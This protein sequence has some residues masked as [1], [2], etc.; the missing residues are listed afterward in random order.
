MGGDSGGSAALGKLSATENLLSGLLSGLCCKATNYPLLSW[1]NASQQN[2][3]LQFNISVYRGL[4]MAMMNL[5]WSFI[6][7]QYCTSTLIYFSR[8]AFIAIS[9]SLLSVLSHAYCQHAGGTTAV[10]FWATGFFQKMLLNGRKEVTSTDKI[11]GSFLGGAFSGIPCSLW[12]LTMIQQQRFGG[13]IIS[14]PMNVMKKFGAMTLTRGVTCT[15]GRESLFT[16]SMLSVTP[17]I[18]E[19]LVEKFSMD[20]DLG[21]AAGALSGSFF[22]AVATHPMDT[23][24]TCMQGDCEQA[25]YTNIRGTAT[26]LLKER[27]VPGLFKGLQWRIALIATTFFLVNKFK[28][29]IIPVVF[30]HVME[31]DVKKE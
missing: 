8:D 23:I 27:G 24:K 28:S 7:T 12:E 6:S 20:S 30:P 10:Q 17:L 14:A 21:L 26:V 16:M 5:G 18:Q 2:L 1:K 29:I 3:P 15:M 4:P 31:D 25:L 9:L 22:A 11:C 13:S 19:A